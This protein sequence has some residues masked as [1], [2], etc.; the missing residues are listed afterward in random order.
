MAKIRKMRGG[1]HKHKT[2]HKKHHKGKTSSY[3]R[4]S[5]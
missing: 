5:Y 4:A 3:I 1:I 2:H